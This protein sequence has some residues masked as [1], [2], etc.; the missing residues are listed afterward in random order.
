MHHGIKMSL[1]LRLTGLS[2]AGG[3]D[4]CAVLAPHSP[5]STIPNFLRPTALAHPHA[6]P[7]CMQQRGPPRS[8]QEPL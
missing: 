4:W 8:R 3:W 1:L 5:T 2:V 6:P 7:N